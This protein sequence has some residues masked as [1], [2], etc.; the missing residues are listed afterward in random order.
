MIT[1]LI[2]LQRYDIFNINYKIMWYY[3]IISNHFI[4]LITVVLII[5]IQLM[6]NQNNDID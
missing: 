2:Y 3:I 1:L 5:I 6:I 4:Q